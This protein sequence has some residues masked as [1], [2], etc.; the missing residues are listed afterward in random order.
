MRKTQRRTSLAAFASPPA[1]KA[2]APPNQD[3]T[4]IQ[5]GRGH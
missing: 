4:I 3:V 1:A 5:L 2:G